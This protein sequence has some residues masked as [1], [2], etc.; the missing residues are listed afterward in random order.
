MLS[1]YLHLV[2]SY[3][4]PLAMEPRKGFLTIQATV[5]MFVN[6]KYI[7]KAHYKVKN[8]NLTLFIIR[9]DG[10]VVTLFRVVFYAEIRVIRALALAKIEVQ[11]GLGLRRLHFALRGVSTFYENR[12]EQSELV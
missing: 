3:W 12:D 8:R 6:F 10:V 2:G 5:D 9:V 1:F 7:G 11:Q 4:N